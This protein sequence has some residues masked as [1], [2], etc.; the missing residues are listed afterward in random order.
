[1]TNKFTEWTTVVGNIVKR[2]DIRVLDTIDTGEEGAGTAAV[3]QNVNRLGD[4]KVNRNEKANVKKNTGNGGDLI[5]RNNDRLDSFFNNVLG[6]LRTAKASAV[7]NAR[8]N[9]L[10]NK[11][12]IW[13]RSKIKPDWKKS[14]AD[15]F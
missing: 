14:A 13:I 11:T 3:E 4:I 9:I 12:G 15:N 5:Y 2:G 10:C 8:R 6:K 7:D 1:M